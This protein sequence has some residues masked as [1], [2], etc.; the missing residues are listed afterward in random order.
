MSPG[1][2]IRLLSPVVA[3]CSPLLSCGGGGGSGTGGSVG[4]H[5]PVISNVRLN[6]G[7]A[8]HDNTTISASIDFQDSGGDIA[9]VHLTVRDTNNVVVGGDTITVQGVIGVTSGT[10]TLQLDPSAFPLGTWGLD[11]LFIDAHGGSSNPLS[12]TVRIVP[13]F[14]PATTY[15]NLLP[16]LFLG[17]IVVGDLDADGRNDIA[18]IQVGIDVNYYIS[19]L[20]SVYYQ[21]STGIFD[22]GGLIQTNMTGGVGGVAI[23]DVTGDGRPD[24]VVSGSPWPPDVM[25]AF[26]GRIA[27]YA[28]QP[29]G[30]LGGPVEYT[31]ALNDPFDLYGV[32]AIAIADLDGDGRNDVVVLS[33]GSIQI[34]YGNAF[35]TLDNAVTILQGTT[36]FRAWG[37]IRTVDLD[38]DG[39]L[40]NGRTGMEHVYRYCETNCSAFVRSAGDLR[41]T[42]PWC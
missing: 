30:T 23:A 31:V 22:S 35:G 6:T 9:E 7:I 42:Y 8:P 40:R 14:G 5:P 26:N 37:G 21:N 29:D 1:R 39:R 12:T 38:N 11:I 13:S 32:G 2:N 25:S 18:M 4:S 10:I 34:L 17:G 19:G 41:Y 36:S 27:V 28:Q 16:H 15:P 20:V 24:L 33:D 3:F